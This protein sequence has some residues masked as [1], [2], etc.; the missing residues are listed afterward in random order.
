MK[1]KPNNATIYLSNCVA[2][3]CATLLGLYYLFSIFIICVST[4]FLDKESVKLRLGS[5][6]LNLDYRSRINRIYNL[7]FITRRITLS[8]LSIFLM[9]YSGIQ[10]MLLIGQNFLIMI[11]I[12]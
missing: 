3:T 10:V 6:Y 9:D 7:I 5:L 4:E 2:I 12:G 1:N 11:F 8:A